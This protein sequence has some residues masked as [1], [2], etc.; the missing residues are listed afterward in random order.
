MPASSPST[1]RPTR[2]DKWRALSRP[3]RL[4]LLALLAM[5][6]VMDLSLRA[7]G[8]RGTQRWL[9]LNRSMPPRSHPLE[10]ETMA[11]AQRLAELAAIAGRQGPLNTTCLRQ[12]LAVQWWL[13]RRRL[14]SQL[15]IGARRVGD[16][17]DAHAWVE[18]DG[19][20]LAQDDLLH[21]AFE[22]TARRSG[23]DPRN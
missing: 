12:A 2:W 6:Q 14:D 22:S 17:L 3:D 20:P 18:L 16:S 4:R 21:T 10:A 19:A 13:R 5:L 9:G 23:T 1:D 11:S 15:R 7:V 8:L